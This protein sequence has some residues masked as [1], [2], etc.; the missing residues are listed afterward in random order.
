MIEMPESTGSLHAGR[1]KQPVRI[2]EINSALVFK[3]TT[4]AGHFI[5]L[6]DDD[7]RNRETALCAEHDL[8]LCLTV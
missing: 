6:I 3:A 2:T 5:F 7:S 8:T 1:R 4:Q